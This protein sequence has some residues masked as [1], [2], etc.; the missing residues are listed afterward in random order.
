[1][2]DKVYYKGKKWQQVCKKAGFKSEFLKEK[3]LSEVD[4]KKVLELLKGK[5]LA[6]FAS[7]EIRRLNFYNAIFL[8]FFVDKFFVDVIGFFKAKKIKLCKTPLH[9]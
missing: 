6:T 3:N 9:N 2:V 8:L 5:K 1:M 4:G 7:L